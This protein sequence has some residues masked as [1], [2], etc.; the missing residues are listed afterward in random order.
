MNLFV[1]FDSAVDESQTEPILSSAH[2]EEPKNSDANIIQN[3]V[4][5][6][7]QMASCII[8]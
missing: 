1:K 3:Y 2:A 4:P 5:L 6:V 8:E 7:A